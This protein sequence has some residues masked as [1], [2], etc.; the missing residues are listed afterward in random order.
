[1][2]L[3]HLATAVLSFIFKAV[4]IEALISKLSG[5]LSKRLFNQLPVSAGFSNSDL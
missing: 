5:E 2:I 4:S 1:M 3:A